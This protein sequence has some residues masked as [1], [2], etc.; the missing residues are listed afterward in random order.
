MYVCKCCFSLVLNEITKW[1]LTDSVSVQP[2]PGVKMKSVTLSTFTWHTITSMYCTVIEIYLK[3]KKRF[4]LW[5]ATCPCWVDVGNR[6]GKLEER[7]LFISI[8]MFKPFW[9]EKKKN[10][11]SSIVSHLQA[12]SLQTPS[13]QS[14]M[15][16]SALIPDDLN[17]P[18][19]G[20]HFTVQSNKPWISVL[21]VC[22]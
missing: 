5:T 19:R 18:K 14:A 11:S 7:V 20:L 21:Y 10:Q 2:C 6:N 4:F 22:K 16:S 3:W 9:K 8:F 17:R 13:C 15:K 12:R 1:Q